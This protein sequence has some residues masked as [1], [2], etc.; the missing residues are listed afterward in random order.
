[1]AIAA[2]IFFEVAF[3]GLIFLCVELSCGAPS[4][5]ASKLCS[6]IGVVLRR[7]GRGRGEGG[8]ACVSFFWLFGAGVFFCFLVWAGA[9]LGCLN[10]KKCYR[11]SSPKNN[12]RPNSKKRPPP[13]RD[14]KNGSAQTAKNTRTRPNSK[15]T[16][17][18]LKQ[19][20]KTRP[21]T[22]LTLQ[23]LDELPMLQFTVSVSSR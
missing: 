21:K 1:M 15:N 10:S 19:Q 16:Q 6:L 22:T 12:L 17:G 5:F 23:A 18:P 4:H 8:G 7:R 11:P 20:N 14:K 3:S 9:W 13:K 2:G